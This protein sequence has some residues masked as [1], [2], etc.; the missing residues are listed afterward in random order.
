MVCIGEILDQQIQRVDVFIQRKIP[1]YRVIFRRKIPQRVH[2]RLIVGRVVQIRAGQRRSEKHKP[3]AILLA[4]IH[5]LAQIFPP[6]IRQRRIGVDIQQCVECVLRR[7]AG[8]DEPTP[9][10]AFA[11]VGVGQVGGISRGVAV[12]QLGAPE[13][14]QRTGAGYAVAGGQQQVSKRR[15]AAHLGLIGVAVGRS[16]PH[17]VGQQVAGQRHIFGRALVVPGVKHL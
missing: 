10:V 16:P 9:T 4:K 8:V 5:G 3:D 1:V 15:Q 13:R 17:V 11:F 6:E 12:G 2:I 7:A 14:R